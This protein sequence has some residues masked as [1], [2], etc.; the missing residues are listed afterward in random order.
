MPADIA[1]DC[2][3]MVFKETIQNHSAIMG[4]AKGNAVSVHSLVRHSGAQKFQREDPIEA[5]SVEMIL[6]LNK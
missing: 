5:A 6:Q 2:A 4:E 3:E 1:D